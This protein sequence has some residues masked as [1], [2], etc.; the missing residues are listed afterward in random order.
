MV[1]GAVQLPPDGWPVVLGPDH[2]TVGGYPVVAV[3]CRS[4]FPSCGQLRP[5][6]RVHFETAATAGADATTTLA[7]RSVTGWMSIDLGAS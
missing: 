4:S 3:V 6:D 5:G 2:G 1:T 7:R